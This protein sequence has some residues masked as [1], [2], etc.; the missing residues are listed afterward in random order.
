M[1][2]NKHL[3]IKFYET[4][5]RNSKFFYSLKWSKSDKSWVKMGF[6]QFSR[7]TF[8]ESFV[9]VT[10]RKGLPLCVCVGT[11][12][13]DS[14]SYIVQY[15][16]FNIFWSSYHMTWFAASLLLFLIFSHQLWE[17]NYKERGTWGIAQKEYLERAID[18]QQNW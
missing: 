17:E 11:L 5:R 6:S 18:S 8:T 3:A 12:S 4:F 13:S 15:L 14:S 16:L 1:H 9:S 10:R 2:K 7:S